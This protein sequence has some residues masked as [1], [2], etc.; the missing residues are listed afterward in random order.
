MEVDETQPVTSIQIRLA[1]GTR[2]VQKF[3]MNHKVADIRNF[4]CRLAASSF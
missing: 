1:N 4:I 2:I 3:N